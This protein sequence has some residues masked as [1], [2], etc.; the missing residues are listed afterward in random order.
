MRRQA[1]GLAVI[2]AIALTS[3]SCSGAQEVTTS[4]EVSQSNVDLP[5]EAALPPLAAP[6]DEKPG[7]GDRA[8]AGRVAG[9][10]VA[11]QDLTEQYRASPGYPTNAR[12]FRILYV[13][14]KHDENDLT[15]VCGL[16]ATPNDGPRLF[17]K[18]KLPTMRMVTHNHGTIGV[19]QRCLP[20]SAPENFFWGP[21]PA[22]IG[23]V[24][25]GTGLINN[26]GLPENG[27]LQ[28]MMNQGWVV[29]ASDYLPADTYIIGRVAA[30][31]VIDAARATQQLITEK[32]PSKSFEQTDVIL[33]G[34]SQGGHATL[35]AGQL[36]ETYLQATLNKSE[37]VSQT[38][39]QGS[40][41]PLRLVG[42]WAQAPASNFIVQPEKQPDIPLGNGLA[43][44]EMHQEL[45][46]IGLPLKALELEIGPA[47]AGYIFAS[48][49]QFSKTNFERATGQAVDTP[50]AP[51][52]SIP[53]TLDAIAT[54]QGKGTIEQVIDLCLNATD[55]GAMKK[56]VSPYVDAETNQLLLPQLWNLPKDYE[57]GEYFKAA[58]DK[59]CATTRTGGIADW[60]EWLRWNLPGPNGLNPYPKIAMFEG[61]PVPTVIGQGMN[62]TVIHCVGGSKVPLPQDCMAVA[63]YESLV[64]N[65]C[66]TGDSEYY[67]R[68]HLYQK[69]AVRSPAT[70][71]S[72]PGQMAAKGTG[73]SKADLSFDG[74]VWQQY[75]SA[76][77]DDS[78]TTGC[79]LSI[80]NATNTQ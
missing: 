55:A 59:T 48:W 24:A 21:S 73:W 12:V 15:L 46:T 35:W 68:L 25:Y 26:K 7:P 44:W 29:S 41:P 52:T 32:F 43:D 31:N 54:S 22:G 13:S 40:N 76:A 78:L 74:S 9:D 38:A 66:P 77:F 50:A 75:L 14:T 79:Q 20:S 60:C 67:L 18:N 1:F 11:A 37:I 61:A 33:T 23:A 30:A 72:L 19:Q 42:Q 80:A 36:F 4:N 34:H 64:P 70:H 45:E 10:L 3:S 47:L 5:A 49:A 58:F 56:A 65:Y 69:K 8:P 6:C 62:D 2:C 17:D 71:L 53:L 16:A 63:L 57:K 51:N 27:M 39:R 28:Y